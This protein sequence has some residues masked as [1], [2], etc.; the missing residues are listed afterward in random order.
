MS[1]ESV[2]T[3]QPSPAAPSIAPSPEYP[4]LLAEA[5]QTRDVL[6][7]FAHAIDRGT[8]EGE[9]CVNI[10]K[11]QAFLEA[12]IKQN[13]G[14]IVEIEKRIAAQAPEVQS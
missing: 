11:G 12:L 3:P 14:H 2:E 1:N 10:A 13:E 5:K 4:A 8:Y 9:E 7:G 6:V